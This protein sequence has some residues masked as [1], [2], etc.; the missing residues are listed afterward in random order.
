MSMVGREANEITLFIGE[1]TLSFMSEMLVFVT[2][3]H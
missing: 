2:T 3:M 1:T